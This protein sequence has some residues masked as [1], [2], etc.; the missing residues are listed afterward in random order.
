[1]PLGDSEMAA[2]AFWTRF[3]SRLSN[4]K[5]RILRLLAGLAR[6]CFACRQRIATKAAEALKDF[7]TAP[8]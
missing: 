1:M 3:A 7:L 4:N 6:V 8:N 2:G 5:N